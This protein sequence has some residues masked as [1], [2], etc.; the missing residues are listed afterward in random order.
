M[1]QQSLNII[2]GEEEES[3][4]LL[5]RI[6]QPESAQFENDLARDSNLIAA[7]FN[8]HTHTFSCKKYRTGSLSQC[9]FGAPWKVVERSYS[10]EDGTMHLKRNELYVNK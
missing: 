5:E 9:Q 6:V 3:E 8:M 10:D 2:E 7:R 1:I 4:L